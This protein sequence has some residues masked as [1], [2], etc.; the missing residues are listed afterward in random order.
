MTE[1]STKNT[2]YDSLSLASYGV[3]GDTRTAVLVSATGSIDWACFP[4]FD[5]PSVFG[6][7]LGRGA[8]EFSI[9]PTDAYRSHQ[10]YESG[11]NIVVTEFVCDSGRLRVRDFMP[12][13]PNRKVATAE[14]HRTVECIEGQVR[15]RLFF[16]PR[17]NYGR[18][19]ANVVVK[20]HGAIFSAAENSL[21]LSSPTPLS[22]SDG[23]AGTTFTMATGE[24]LSFVADWGATEVYPVRSYQTYRRIWE[25]RKAWR[26][27]IGRLAYHGRYRDAVERS[28]LTLKLL[29]YEPTGAIIAAPTTSLPEWIGG[30]RNW[31][32]RYTWIRD[33]AFILG[34]FFRAGF[35]DEGTAYFDFILKRVFKGRDLRILYDIH[36]RENPTEAELQHLEGYAGSGP[37]R[38]GNGAAEQHQLDIYGSLLDAAW[39]YYQHGGVITSTEWQALTDIIALV[40]NKWRDTDSGIWEARSEEQHYTYSKIWAWVALD[41][42][43]KLASR[44]G[45][46]DQV[47][48]WAREA[49][50]IKA[51]VLEGAWNESLQSFTQYY[52]SPTI[53]AALL[54]MAETGFIDVNDARFV[55]TLEK[56][57]N[58]LGDEL[59][60]LFYRYD[61]GAFD[62]GIREPEG[63]FLLMSFWYIDCLILL[64][65]LPEA[66][67]ALE[68]MIA[69]ATPLG[70]YSECL[71]TAADT[72]YRF[73][74][75]FPQGFSHLGLVNS[76]FKLDQM[77]RAMEAGDA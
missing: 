24:E 37:V 50:T 75:N 29:S 49:D 45:L 4:D 48:T 77:R 7:L 40:M 34:A 68:Q 30:S 69:M 46:V 10:F 51:H 8:G 9:A 56:I 11:T 73:L 57:K 53:D 35:I 64:K 16:S 43:V 44:L 31:D 17:F 60:P 25:T 13:V 76:I 32:Y 65:K 41:R 52:G 55:S 3:I 47:E 70:L 39:L 6:R 66:R 27:W 2:N 36:G 5:S 14:I 63:R 54:V 18:E 21:T 22:A 62:D 74:G 72:P 23:A 26:Q 71:D 61:S 38:I 59:T 20:S 19:K 1:A 12:Y 58:S 28:L 33:S 67:A 15:V 42:A